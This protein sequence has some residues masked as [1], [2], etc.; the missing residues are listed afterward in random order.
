MHWHQKRFEDVI[1]ELG[2]SIKGLSAAEALKRLQEYGLNELIE[3]KKKTLFIRANALY[4]GE[5]IKQAQNL[6]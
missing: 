2:S 5:A 6:Q 4:R 1:D 3:K